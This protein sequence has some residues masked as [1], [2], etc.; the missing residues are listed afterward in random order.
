MRGVI[1]AFCLHLY[2]TKHPPQARNP[3]FFYKTK[4]Y[5]IRTIKHLQVY[6]NRITFAFL[7][8]KNLFRWY[9]YYKSKFE[10]RATY[11]S[12]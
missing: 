11:Y 7:Q 8:N 4:K 6:S 2:Q 5:L 12:L 10:K 9:V 1:P 3:R